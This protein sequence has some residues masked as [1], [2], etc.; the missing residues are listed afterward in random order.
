MNTQ[1]PNGHELPNSTWVN[2]AMFGSYWFL[3]EEDA[4]NSLAK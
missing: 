4:N 1:N 2:T 3:K